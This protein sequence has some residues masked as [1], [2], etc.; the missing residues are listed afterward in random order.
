MKSHI[1]MIFIFFLYLTSCQDNEN[2]NANKEREQPLDNFDND[3]VL[4]TLNSA[5]SELQSTRKDFFTI[6]INAM[7][8]FLADDIMNFIIEKKSEEVKIKIIIN[9]KIIRYSF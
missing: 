9:G 2:S 8:D 1:L 7:R 5:K 4:K 3:N 6:W